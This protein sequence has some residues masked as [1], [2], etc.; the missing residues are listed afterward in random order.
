MLRPATEADKE[1]IRVWRNHPQVREVSLTRDVISVQ[2]H[3]RYWD[4][5]QDNPSR[6]VLMYDRGETPSGVVTFFDI[7]QVA[8][9]DTAAGTERHAMWGYYLDNDGLQDRGELIPAW[10]KIQR[11][12]VRYAFDELGLDQLDGEVLDANEAV[13]RM[14]TRN[15]F[16][17]ISA[18]EHTIDGE[19]VLVHTIRR[20]RQQRDN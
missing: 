3:Q 16:E 12:A 1:S 7:G 6:I 2:E 14:N 10:I 4:S 15:G 8:T 19:Q 18:T 5:L 11:E 20:R 17:E 13:R 9:E